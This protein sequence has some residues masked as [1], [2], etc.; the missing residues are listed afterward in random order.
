MT[1][2]LVAAVAVNGV[3]GHDGDIP[4]RLPADQARFKRLTTGHVL[5]MGRRTYE[6]IG[7]PLPDRTT[8]VVTGQPGW[9]DAA[10]DGV[11]VAGSIEAALA[12]ALAVDPEVFVVGGVEVYRATL[13]LADR[14]E[15]TLVDAEPPGDAWFPPV[16]WSSWDEV[17]REPGDGFTFVSF[18]RRDPALGD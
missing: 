10:P 3:I 12:L 9:A 1:V 13:P 5:V 17:A 4:W 14:L 2:T 7:R 18:V 16:D 8:V 11:Q 15:L 6:S